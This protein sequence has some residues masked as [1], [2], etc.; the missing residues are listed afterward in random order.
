MT[1][2]ADRESRRH[3]P[4]ITGPKAVVDRIRIVIDRVGVGIIV[5]NPTRLINNHF[6]RLIIRN[7]DDFLVRGL[8]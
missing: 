8:D 7:V 5:I 6:L 4:E 1:V 3:A 2:P